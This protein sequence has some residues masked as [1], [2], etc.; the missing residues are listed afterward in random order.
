MT[1]EL[2]DE[3]LVERAQKGDKRAFELLVRQ[4]DILQYKIIPQMLVNAVGG[5][6]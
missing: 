3:Q 2:L 1:E 4:E 6:A 5:P